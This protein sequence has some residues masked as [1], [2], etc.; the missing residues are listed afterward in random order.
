MRKLLACHS[1]R[2]EESRPEVLPMAASPV[3]RRPDPSG[4]GSDRFLPRPDPDRDS[5]SLRSGQAFAALRSEWHGER[6]RSSNRTSLTRKLDP[7]VAL[8]ERLDQQALDRFFGPAADGGN[9]VHQ[10]LPGP[11]EHPLL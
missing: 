7:E 9:L 6:L 11:V 2:S 5:R 10:E 4:L 8:A 3:G 1:E